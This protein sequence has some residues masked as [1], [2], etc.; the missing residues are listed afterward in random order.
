[1]NKITFFILSVILYVIT[2]GGLLFSFHMW[3]SSDDSYYKNM[4]KEFY[5]ALG[6]YSWFTLS[7]KKFGPRIWDVQS[8]NYYTRKCN[9]REYAVTFGTT[10]NCLEPI[11][12][13]EA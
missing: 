8:R 12:Q 7:I 5:L 13:Q 2:L 3:R 4:D 10:S 1:M 11:K 9:K 6:N